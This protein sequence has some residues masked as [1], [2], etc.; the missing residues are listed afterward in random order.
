MRPARGSRPGI[1]VIVEATNGHDLGIVTLEGP[2][3]GR[4]DEV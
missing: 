2:V 3:V 1:W 4:L